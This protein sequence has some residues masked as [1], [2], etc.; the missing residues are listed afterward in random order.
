MKNLS[1]SSFN[2]VSFKNNS[3]ALK[4]TSNF[5]LKSILYYFNQKIISLQK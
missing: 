1:I 5:K 4:N 2:I 3:N